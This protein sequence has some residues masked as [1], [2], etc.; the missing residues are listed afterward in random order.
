VNATDA[1]TAPVEPASAGDAAIARIVHGPLAAGVARF[2]LPLVVGMALHTTFNLVDMAMIGQLPNGGVGLA[3]LG[4]C[5]MVAAVATILSNGVSTATVAL[6]AQRSGAGDAH[7]VARATRQSLL[8]VGALSLV[9]GLVGV[10]AS[11]FVI[12]G[13]LHAQGEVADVAAA[14][15]QVLL[16][17]CFSIFFLLQITA[18]LR[19]RGQGTAAAALLVAGN[20]LN[21][22]LN[23]F[24]IFG[25]GAYPDVLAFCAPMGALLGAPRLGVLGAAWATLFGRA[26]PVLVG[27]LMLVMRRDAPRVR[28][29]DLRPDGVELRR[30]VRIAWPASA[31]FVLRVASILVFLGLLGAHYTTPDDASA[32]TA[33]SICLRLETMALFVGM[34]W[35]AAAST[36]VGVNL[37]AGQPA[38]ARHAGLWAAGFNAVLM[39]GLTALYLVFSREIMGFFDDSPAVLAAGDEYLWR[40]GATYAVLG[41]G[42]VLSQAMAGAGA[43]LPSLVLDAVVLLGLTIPLAWLVTG[44]LGLARPWL[45]NAIALGYVISALAYLAYY[46]RKRTF[47]GAGEVPSASAP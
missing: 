44:P 22:A 41:V 16:G 43:T 27:A 20:V 42:V 17:G 25:T 34:G 23:P 5:D 7:G 40:V 39:V 18:I 21:V 46:L 15:L 11:D 6:I 33:Y 32:L 35:G 26:V 45:W 37:G 10:F 19:A 1:A 38:R 29:A 9:F 24:L 28:L 8:L 14:Y 4:L 47:A 3:A 36:Y 2:G 12:R 30:L 13:V 31:Q